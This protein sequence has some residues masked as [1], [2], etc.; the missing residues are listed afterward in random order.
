V[1]AVVLSNV[2]VWLRWTLP[3]IRV[4]QM[5][6]LAWKY[7]VP[8]AFACFV[9]T[10]VWQLLVGAAPQ[11]ELWTGVVFTIA[12]AGVAVMFARRVVDNIKAVQGDR[13]DLS[14]W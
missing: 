8:I 5:M 10:L 9:F 7:L 1:K 3:R 4:D 11:V 2:V 12:T 14:N 13:F 6:T